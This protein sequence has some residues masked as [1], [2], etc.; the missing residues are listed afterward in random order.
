VNFFNCFWFF[1]L[2]SIVKVHLFYSNGLVDFFFG[3]F[4]FF[5]VLV[6]FATLYTFLI[7]Y[8][9]WYIYFGKIFFGF[10]S[11]FCVGF[12]LFL[13]VLFGYVWL[14]YFGWFGS[15]AFLLDLIWIVL[16]FFLWRDSVLLVGGL[17]E[18]VFLVLLFAAGLFQSRLNFVLFWLSCF[19][20]YNWYD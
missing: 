11:S 9:C 19:C 15:L 10:C 2:D 18:F 4:I 3:S 13:L 14:V 16:D 12:V 5:F 8:L 7:S 6:V 20:G 1:W 17:V